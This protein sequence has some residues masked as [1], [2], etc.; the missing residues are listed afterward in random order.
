MNINCISAHKTIPLGNK[1]VLHYWYFH[2]LSAG[3]ILLWRFLLTLFSSS[4]SDKKTWWI[5]N[6]EWAHR[7]QQWRQQTT[8]SPSPAVLNIKLHKLHNT[9]RERTARSCHDIGGNWVMVTS[10]YNI[11][12]L[13]NQAMIVSGIFVWYVTITQ[14]LLQDMCYCTNYIV[15]YKTRPVQVWNTF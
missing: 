9:R 3:E 4:K 15:G 14:S 7:E 2:T 13:N 10:G 8:V 6:G 12:T 11:E 5:T 1:T